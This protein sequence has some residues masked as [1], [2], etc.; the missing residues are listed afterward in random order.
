MA[1]RDL[2]VR[3]HVEGKLTANERIQV[4]S[5]ARIEGDI[6]ADRISIE[7]GAELHGRLEAGKLSVVAASSGIAGLAT[8]MDAN[9]SKDASGADEKPTPGAAVAGAN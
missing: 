7:E 8:R 9:K 6:K 4:W 5:T 3:G 2:V 1:A